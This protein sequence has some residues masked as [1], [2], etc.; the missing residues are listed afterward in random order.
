MSQDGVNIS[1]QNV[2]VGGDLNITVITGGEGGTK[3]ETNLPNNESGSNAPTQKP[4]SNPPTTTNTSKKRNIVIE[5]HSKNTQG[6]IDVTSKGSEFKALSPFIGKVRYKNF[7]TT[8]EGVWQGFKIVRGK[9]D[10]NMIEGRNK[11]GKRGEPSDENG[12]PFTDNKGHLS[13]SDNKTRLSIGEAQ[14]QIYIPLYNRLLDSNKDLI[15]KL[16]NIYETT[17]QLILRDFDLN[18]EIGKPKLSHASLIAKRVNQVLDEREKNK[19]NNQNSNKLRPKKFND[20]K[21]RPSL[22]YRYG[23]NRENSLNA[24]Q[25]SLLVN[26]L[27]ACFFNIYNG[28]GRGE[29]EA[30]LRVLLSEEGFIKYLNGRLNNDDLTNS[31]KTDLLRVLS[32]INQYKTA[33]EEA[34]RSILNELFANKEFSLVRELEKRVIRLG[35]DID[36]ITLNKDAIEKI[37]TDYERMVKLADGTDVSEETLNPDSHSDYDKVSFDDEIKNKYIYIK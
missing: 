28:E 7:F 30:S 9:I 22:F 1:L 26:H 18:E 14:T 5:H 8:V 24:V 4:T 11:P 35:F 6:A 33:D 2:T 37:R 19:N 20:A 29:Y 31:V 15:E 17:G 12:K 23:E 27:T 34:K 16:A 25:T 36:A 21:D 10:E 3:V 32:L 13:P